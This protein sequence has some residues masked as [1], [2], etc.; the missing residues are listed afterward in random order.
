M[1]ERAA[2]SIRAEAP[3]CR[4]A[5]RKG[6]FRSTGDCCAAVG[7]VNDPLILDRTSVETPWRLNLEI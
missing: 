7:M 2:F 6:I 5:S 1:A 4:I 3:P